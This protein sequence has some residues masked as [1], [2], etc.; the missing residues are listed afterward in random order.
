MI[1]DLNC[2]EFQATTGLSGFALGF[3]L[4]P[5]VTASFSEEFGRHPLY[6]GSVLGFMLTH[7][8]VALYVK[9]DAPF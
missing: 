8:M 3:A 6:L 1:H 4:V 9:M 7:L 5:L 2:T